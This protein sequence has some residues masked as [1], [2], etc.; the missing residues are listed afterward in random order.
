M[1]YT[2]MLD[3]SW[4]FNVSGICKTKLQNIK[5]IPGPDFPIYPYKP[6]QGYYDIRLY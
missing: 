4:L 3:R 6:Y 5:D 2:I 1:L